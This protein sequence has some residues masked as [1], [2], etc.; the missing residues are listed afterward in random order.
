MRDD[1]HSR[2]S[3]APAL[4]ARAPG[5]VNLIGEHI[6]YEG[7]AVLPMAIARDCVVAIALTGTTLDVS[8]RDDVHYPAYTFVPDPSQLVDTETHVW[9]NYAL[10]AYK[11][12]HDYLEGHPEQKTDTS[13]S[14]P[15]IKVRALLAVDLPCYAR[16]LRARA[17]DCACAG[18]ILWHWRPSAR[19]AEFSGCRHRHR[20]SCEHPGHKTDT[21]K[22][23]TGIKVRVLLAI[24]L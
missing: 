18:G 7:Y 6:D 24:D 11:G 2:Y 17:P 1:F 15:G 13:K 4:F 10:A 3:A 9:A 22:S 16:A 12:V 23:N 21:S 8:N 14:N 19:C 5:R 20:H